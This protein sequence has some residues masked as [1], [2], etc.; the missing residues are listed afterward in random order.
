MMGMTGYGRHELSSERYRITAELRSYNSRYL[1]L[2]VSLPPTLGE[3]EPRVRRK[4]DERL[5]RGRVEAHVLVADADSAVEVEV[6]EPLVVAYRRALQKLAGPL[7]QTVTIDHLLSVGALLRERRPQNAEVVW[8]EAELVVDGALAQLVAARRSEG[9]TAEEDVIAQLAKLTAELDAIE[10]DSAAD[11]DAIAGARTKGAAAR[12]RELLG[13][14]A[15]DERVVAALAT[16][17]VRSD[18]NEELVRGRGHL[19]ALQDALGKDGTGKHMEFLCQETL[20]EVNTIA[21]KSS[22]Y[23]VAAAAVRA[24]GCLERMREQLRNVE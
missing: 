9:E 1:E 15:D 24:K 20:R 11:A 14:E 5:T 22:S 16:L 4:L 13:S 18:I 12:A 10:R 21:S 6:N 23:S 8:S 19:V 17:F 2:S 7:G 3:L